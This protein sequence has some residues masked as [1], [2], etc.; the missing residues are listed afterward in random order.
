MIKPSTYI[1]MLLLPLLAAAMLASCNKYLD[2]K[3]KG[4]RLLESVNDYDLWMNSTDIAM[5]VLSDINNLGDN[6]D[7]ANVVLPTTNASTLMYLWADQYSTDPKTLPTLWGQLYKN[8]Y[9]F[10]T[11][12]NGVD[13]AVNGTEQQKKSLKAEALLGRA[14]EYI[15]L[16]NFYAKPYDPAT[17]NKD[18][19]VPFVTSSDLNDAAPPRSTVKGIYDQVIADINT[20]LPDLP[21]DNSKNRFR[22]TV[23]AAYSVLARVYLYMRDY[24]KAAQNAQL[25]LDNGPNA[26]LDYSSMASAAEISV[27]MIRPN[28]IYARHNTSTYIQLTPTIGALKSFDRQDIRL[29]FYYSSLGDYTFNKRGVTYY[30]SISLAYSNSYPNCGTSVEEMRL[31]L[32]EAAARAG[33]LPKALEELHQVRKCRFPKS[34]YT[35]FESADKEVVLQK[36]L[37]ERTFEFAYNGTRWF[38]MRRLDME[39]RMP[40]LQ[41]LDGQSKVIS[42]LPVHSKKYTLQIP[43]SVMY[44]HPDWEQ[45]PWD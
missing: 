4:K 39:N 2:I 1:R 45:N 25:A 31:I 23:A 6:V 12:L 10:N 17:A 22:G 43:L 7:M 26:V 38:D 9:N 16:V 28:A 3:P 11:V 19:A 30:I 36:I 33:D 15:N 34:Y 13:G 42:T 44:F 32:A 27:L 20:A 24:P 14:F 8:I 18:M 37:L 41:R 5:S 29:Q 40:E 35:K 21:K